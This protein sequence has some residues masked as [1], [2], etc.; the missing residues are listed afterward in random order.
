MMTEKPFRNV[1]WAL[2]TVGIG[3]IGEYIDQLEK[4]FP[5]YSQDDREAFDAYR[6]LIY[7]FK[8]SMFAGGEKVMN[9][10]SDL[11]LEL[12]LGKNAVDDR[13]KRLK[14][15]GL[16]KSINGLETDNRRRL[17]TTTEEAERRFMRLSLHMLEAMKFYLE[18]AH[19]RCDKFPDYSPIEDFLDPLPD[20]IH[21]R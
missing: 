21:Q 18:L 19:S 9:A 5:E 13:L 3:L 17:L 11:Q 6:I 7:L 20:G 12:K 15:E 2:A 14:D 4:L 16:I 10:Q 1:D 8:S